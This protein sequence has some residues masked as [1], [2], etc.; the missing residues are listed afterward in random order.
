[1]LFVVKH[2]DFISH[3]RC[4]PELHMTE[5]ALLRVQKLSAVWTRLLLCSCPPLG[6]PV[7][8]WTSSR[9]RAYSCCLMSCRC[10]LSSIS[11]HSCTA[12]C[13]STC[14]GSPAL[15]PSSVGENHGLKIFSQI[16]CRETGR[17]QMMSVD[18]SC[19]SLLSSC[20]NSN[21]AIHRTKKIF[22]STTRTFNR[23]KQR[24]NP[25]MPQSL[26]PAIIRHHFDHLITTSLMTVLTNGILVQS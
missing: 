6:C 24:S 7:S 9:R 18:E 4:S 22:Q 2:F 25:L 1:M 16:T 10:S 15:A 5:L 11:A 20:F 19:L 12:R 13:N 14:R 17:V 21:T 8:S 23:I 26:I 3:R